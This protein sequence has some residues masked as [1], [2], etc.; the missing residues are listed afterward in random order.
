VKPGSGSA[1]H[2]GQSSGQYLGSARELT[3]TETG[4]LMSESGGLL[5]RDVDESSPASI[6]NRGDDDEIAHPAQQVLSETARILTHL[7]D[8]VDR[9]KDLVGIT[10]SESVDGLVKESVRGVTE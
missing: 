2:I 7:N 6:R 10:G 1:T 4:H 9:G 5:R 8:L 3:G